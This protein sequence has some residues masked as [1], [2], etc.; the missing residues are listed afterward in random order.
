MRLKRNSSRKKMKLSK[1]SIMFLVVG[2]PL[3]FLL[4]LLIIGYQAPNGI[5]MFITAAGIFLTTLRKKNFGIRF[6][7]ASFFSVVICFFT[8]GSLVENPSLWGQQIYRHAFKSTLIQPNANKI[9]ELH[10]AFNWWLD[11]HSGSAGGSSFDLGYYGDNITDTSKPMENKFYNRYYHSIAGVDLNLVNFENRSYFTEFER[12]MIVDTFIRDAIIIWTADEFTHHISDHVPTPDEALVQWN[13]NSAWQ[14]DYGNFSNYDIHARDDCDG[15]AVV[16]VSFLR[17]LKAQ[18]LMESDGFYI[19]S[20]VRHWFAG[21]RVNDSTPMLFLNHWQSVNVFC[22]FNDNNLPVYGQNLLLTMEYVLLANEDDRDEFLFYIGFV[23]D[24]MAFLLPIAAAV[25]SILAVALL[26]YPR[27]YNPGAERAFMDKAKKKYKTATP[28]LLH[29][30]IWFGYKIH[31][32]FGKRHLFFWLN[33]IFASVMLIIGVN[34]LYNLILLTP[35]YTYSMMF[36]YGYLFAILFL[37]DRDVVTMV[38]KWIYK[39]VKGKEIDL[40]SNRAGDI[41]EMIEQ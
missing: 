4:I 20:G 13:F 41:H 10:S 2:T 30:F 37:I 15:I 9:V 29:P 14:N 19:A 38:T 5:I 8:V 35:L 31:N 7:R 24:D 25:I 1:Q 11:N 28:G 21:I 26:G 22:Y 34:I 27:D 3:F 16:T 32:P 33:V 17:R 39:Q 40:Y 36:L 18:G 12:L 23:M 6:T